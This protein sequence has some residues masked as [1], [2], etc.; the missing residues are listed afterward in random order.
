MAA[1][2]TFTL[3]HRLALDVRLR[4]RGTVHVYVTAAD[5]NLLTRKGDDALD[6]LAALVSRVLEHDYVAT[7]RRS[8]AKERIVGED[9]VADE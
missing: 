8:S 3:D 5:L 4:E 6:E 1:V 7:A 2:A 9:V